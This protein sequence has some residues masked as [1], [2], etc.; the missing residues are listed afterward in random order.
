[1]PPFTGGADLK[2]PLT[3]SL[4]VQPWRRRRWMI[5]PIGHDQGQLRRW[6]IFSFAIIIIC[7]VLEMMPP[8]VGSEKLR[9]ADEAFE[10]SL[11]YYLEHLE[12]KPHPLLRAAALRYAKWLPADRR[13]D[14]RMKIEHPPPGSPLS[15]LRQGMLDKKTEIW[16]EVLQKER[17]WQWGYIPHQS[18]STR[19]VTSM[20]LHGGFL[21]LF[22]TM[23]F[24]YLTAPFI[25]DRWGRPLFLIFYLG[26]G[27]VA[28][29]MFAWHQPDIGVPLV[30]ASGAIA[31]LMGAFLV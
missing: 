7:T 27:V 28:A 16:V 9:A 29:L 22:F 4:G 3:M 15:D 25:E 19:L 23:L 2:L 30:G 6:P 12:L 18:D 17:T 14:V 1:H 21:H 11:K 13:Q 20:F 8:T 5:V 26:A 24:L 31:G 10:E